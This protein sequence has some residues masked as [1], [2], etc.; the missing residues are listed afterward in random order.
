MP[1]VLIIDDDR[2][3]PR[4]W[5]IRLGAAGYQVQIAHDGRS[6]LRVAA[7][8]PP[9][10][11]LLDQFMHDIDGLEVCRTLHAN[12]SL[13]HIPVLIMSGN[14]ADDARRNA[15]QAGAVAFLPKPLPVELV[16]AA[17]ETA[18]VSAQGTHAESR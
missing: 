5:Q 9:D 11:I 10:L 17:L 12:P 7:D 6:G 14:P 13:C 1:H 3:L 16:L 4:A 2:A 8:S 15:I 18:L